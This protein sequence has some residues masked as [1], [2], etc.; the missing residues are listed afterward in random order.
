MNP[1]ARGF[2]RGIPQRMANERGSAESAL[3]LIPLLILFLIGMQLSLAIHSRNMAR[4]SAQD[5]ASQR[6]ISGN[7]TGDD[8]FIHIESSGDG[9]NLDL[10]V[11]K[12]QFS[13]DDLLAGA[14]G[15]TGGQR[16]VDVNGVAIVEN[17]R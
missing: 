5:G 2:V 7:F 9:Q 10:V 8:Q 11:T 4:M 1:S 16:F 13:L 15:I 12:N 17:Q 3:V 6:A 14:V